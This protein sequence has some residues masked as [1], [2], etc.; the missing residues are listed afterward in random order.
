[1]KQ[2]D[3][4][5]KLI[6]FLHGR[7]LAFYFAVA[8][9]LVAFTFIID[10]IT[11]PEISISVFYLAPVALL[12]WFVSWPATLA[13]IIVCGALWFGADIISGNTYSSPEI[14]YW[15]AVLRIG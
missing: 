10:I 7:S 9:V 3:S 15:N 2:Q 4:S 12:A 1:M 8:A 6:R 11:G 13:C 14:R 5:S